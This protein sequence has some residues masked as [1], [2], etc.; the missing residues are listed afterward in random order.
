MVPVTENPADG[1]TKAKSA[2]GP[3]FHLLETCTYRPGRLEQLRGVSFIEKLLQFPP[4]TYPLLA[5]R[6]VYIS[7]FS[8]AAKE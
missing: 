8:L 6:R 4:F 2:P 1:L 7:F 5:R 3:L